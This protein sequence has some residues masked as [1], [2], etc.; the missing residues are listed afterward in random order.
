MY[1]PSI[2]KSKSSRTCETLGKYKGAALTAE[3]VAVASLEIVLRSPCSVAK[4]YTILPHTSA[5]SL[6]VEN[7]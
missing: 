7:A 3:K 5:S 4:L 1:L 2:T 6:A